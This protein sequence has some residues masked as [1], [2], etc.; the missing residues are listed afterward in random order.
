VPAFPVTKTDLPS[1]TAFSTDCWSNPRSDRFSRRDSEGR[2][3]GSNLAAYDCD[4]ADADD[5]DA[6][7]ADADDADDDDTDAVDECD[8]DE[9]TA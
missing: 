6:D 9:A 3:A 8:A 1:S 7:D 2:G 4:D 5:A